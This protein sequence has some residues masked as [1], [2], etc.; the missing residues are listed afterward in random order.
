M[1]PHLSQQGSGMVA[2]LRCDFKIADFLDRRSVFG[3]HMDFSEAWRRGTWN[4][5]K[6]HL[7]LL[8]Y[9]EDVRWLGRAQ[10]GTNITSRDRI[11][12]VTEIEEIEAIPIN[13]LLG[14]MSYRH[15]NV[16]SRVGILPDA[17]GKAVIAALIELRPQYED[18]IG[19]LQRPSELRLPDGRWGELLNEER[20]GFGVILDIAGIGRRV[21]R[22]W[23]TPA[24]D[25]PFLAGIPESGELEDHLIAHDVERFGPWMPVPTHQVAW[26]AFQDRRRRVF[27]MNAN[28]TPVEQTLGV[29]VV[30]WNEERASFVLVQYKKM[31]RARAD[32]GMRSTLTYRP[33]RNLQRELERM[34]RVDEICTNDDGEFRLLAA[35]CWLKLCE[36]AARVNDPTELVRGMYLPREHFDELLRTHTGPRGG[37]LLTYENVPRHF[38]NTQFI[39]LVRDGWIGSRGTGTELLRNVIKESIETRHSVVL[40]V[41]TSATGTNNTVRSS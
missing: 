40:G 37:P 39:D 16:V 6:A 25:V 30:Y 41:Q 38:S 27:V 22:T 1:V 7:A 2:L 14:A 5:P 36:S 26:R 10:A 13:D 29:D 8:L 17:G 31:G 4:G 11:V 28:R 33:D 32:H 15:R 34:T 9:E 35:P 24:V 12:R 20:D 18:L 23:S 21:L 3:G 19:R